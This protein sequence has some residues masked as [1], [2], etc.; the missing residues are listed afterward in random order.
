MG[1]TRRIMDTPDPPAERRR[2]LRDS[3]PPCP[4]CHHTNVH[5]AT[6]VDWYFYLRCRDCLNTWSVPKHAAE[7]EA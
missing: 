7:E 3:L 1:F 6:R 4:E 5:V 2:V